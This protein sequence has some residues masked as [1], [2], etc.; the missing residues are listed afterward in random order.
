MEDTQSIIKRDIN[1][2]Y[3]NWYGILWLVNNKNGFIDGSMW[4]KVILF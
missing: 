1:S 2:F 4:I 3:N